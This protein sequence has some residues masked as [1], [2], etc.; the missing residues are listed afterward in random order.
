[1]NSVEMTFYVRIANLV[2]A[3]EYE[4][5]CAQIDTQYRPA[6]RTPGRQSTDPTCL[7]IANSSHRLA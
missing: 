2:A 6:W 4:S 3:N 7:P 1:M 5:V